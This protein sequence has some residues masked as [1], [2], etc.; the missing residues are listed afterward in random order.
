MSR[1]DATVFV[2]NKPQFKPGAGF[3]K[4]PALLEPFGQIRYVI[5]EGAT[6]E[7]NP[8]AVGE[9]AYNRLR[10]FRENV[11]YMAF[12]GGS[13]VGAMI[14]GYVLAEIGIQRLPF[15]RFKRGF[16]G[17]G[18]PNPRLDKFVLEKVD[19]DAIEPV[20]A[21][22]VEDSGRAQVWMLQEPLP[23]RD[24]RPKDI[25]GIEEHGQVRFIL[26]PGQ[27]PDRDLRGTLNYLD[28]S[29]ACFREGLDTVAFAGGSQ[30]AA[31]LLGAALQLN[32]VARPTFLRFERERDENRRPIPGRGGYWPVFF[33]SVAVFGAMPD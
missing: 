25:S 4:D 15:L 18:K 10:S 21:T 1:E 19:L 33:D 30:L 32:G 12:L 27:N 24:G 23:L 8:E 3:F 22:V 26:P 11:D 28:G 14:I 6:P 13:Q 20:S 29:M 16:D 17:P 7:F 5:E 9:L 31:C 2:Q